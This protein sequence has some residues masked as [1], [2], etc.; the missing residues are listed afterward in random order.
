MHRAIDCAYAVAHGAAAH[1]AVAYSAVAHTT[2]DAIVSA[3]L[4][5]ADRLAATLTTGHPGALVAHVQVEAAGFASNAATSSSS[6]TRFLCAPQQKQPQSYR[7]AGS[8]Y[9]AVEVVAVGLQRS[10]ADGTVHEELVDVGAVDVEEQRRILQSIAQKKR[11]SAGCWQSPP[12]KR[13]CYSQ[14]PP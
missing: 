14:G 2:D 11:Y 13:C 7:T 10:K 5:N 8:S 6:I 12:S 9:S 1:S 4:D 3:F